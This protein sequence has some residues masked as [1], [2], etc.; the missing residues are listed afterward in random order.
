MQWNGKRRTCILNLCQSR[1]IH[2]FAYYHHG[3]VG[4]PGPNQVLLT[5]PLL[6]G[7]GEINN[8]LPEKVVL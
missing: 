7:I 1:G 2:T 3:D 5:S 8:K 4:E 6:K